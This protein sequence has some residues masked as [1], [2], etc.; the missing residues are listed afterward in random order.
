MEM[1]KKT[2]LVLGFLFLSVKGF[3]Q[4][5]DTI[6]KTI[7]DSIN[8]PKRT[9]A[10]AADKWAIVRPLN[11][12]FT[13]SAPYNFTS[14]R[15]NTPLPEGKVESFT[16]ARVSA[17]FN[18]IKRKTWLLGATLNYRYTTT[19]T[20]MTDPFT[21]NP[22]TLDEDFH[23]L[24]SAVN[25]SY[26]STLFKKMTIYSSSIIVDG[27]DQHFERVRGLISGVMVLKA[28]RKTKMM[29]GL[30]VNIDPSAQT[31]VVPIFTYEHKFNNGLIADVTLP[32]SIYLRKYVFSNAGRVSL[33][34]E[35]D[36]T[37]FY[38]YNID[39]TSQRYE[40][41]Q[42]DITS[43]LVYE[44]AVGDFVVTAKTGIKLTPSGRLFRKEDNF[45]DA[46]F[47]TSPDP[48]F[49]FNI[50]VSFNPFTFLKK[51]K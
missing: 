50:G 4:V 35:L 20:N 46:V 23:Y 27:S 26:F 8:I 33:G 7:K 36:R 49:Y 13:H 48:T 39:G 31:L 14:E 28:N 9:V 2:A 51:N 45:N 18:F 47:E 37:S 44:H 29:V 10:Y 5:T 21:A 42:L 19:E 40:Y 22:T 34:S 3:S 12:E 1:I 24:S 41:R 32:R 16:Q 25:F 43:G 17:N 6:P 38:L 30:V 11:V 15:G